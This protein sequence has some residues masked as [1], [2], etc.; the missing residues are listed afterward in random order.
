MGHQGVDTIGVDMKV[1]QCVA[2]TVLDS[3]GNPTVEV[4]LW[5]AKGYGMAMVPSGAS[6]GVHEALELRDGG[7]AWK[8]KGV[9]KAVSNINKKIVPK[10][11][12]KHFKDQ[13]DF[14][15]FLLDLDGTPQKRKLGANAL[16]AVSM[17]LS[18][19]S[20]DDYSVPLYDYIGATV[21]TKKITLPIPF[22]NVI[23]GGVHAGNPLEMQE[24]MIVPTGAKSFSEATQIVSETYHELK[25]TIAKKY[26]KNA[27][28]VGD[29][30]GFAPPVKNADDAL[31][32][33]TKAIDKS[34]YSNKLRIAMDAAAGE[35]Y[36]KK[37]KKY[38]SQKLSP[39]KLHKYYEKLT[40][41]YPIISLEDPFDQ[42]DFLSWQVFTAKNGKKLQI[43]GDDLTV[44]NPARVQL[45]AQQN[46]CN[47][48]LL[49]INQIG[50]IS[51]ALTSAHL[52]KLN[53]WNVMVSHR[54]GETE[55]PYI[56]DLAVGLGAGQIKIGAPCRSDRVA[57]YN[58]LLR[59]EDDLGKK[60]KYAKF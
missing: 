27:T 21:Q 36:N 9:S 35:F 25:N 29:E 16:L 4:E 52:A 45:A 32:L 58:Q 10:L 26:D 44:T 54:S 28:N 14:D 34:G 1:K 51:E 30:G 15:E 5:T 38:F 55:D 46:L 57:K 2:R 37:A 40:T 22:A 31:K 60:A 20:A 42:D 11:L 19:A 39:A 8:G 12:G 49:K 17:A 50:T 56:A 13:Q 7:K 24:F 48:L 3:R 53:K 23:N 59:I 33:L 18:R 41:N 47:A 6:T 43:V